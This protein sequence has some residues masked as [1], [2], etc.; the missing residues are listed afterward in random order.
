MNLKTL[1][2]KLKNLLR[3]EKVDK[4]IIDKIKVF[5]IKEKGLGDY[6]T[7]LI[8]LIKQKESGR[9]EEIVSKIKK[10][11][12]RYFEKIEILNDY[13]N[14]SLSDYVLM[15]KLRNSYKNFKRKGFKGFEN[16]VEKKFAKYKVN[17]DYV[18]ANPT[19]PLTLANVR[20]GVYGDV[21]ANILKILGYR[22][23]KEYY[24]N[25]R[26][27][28]IEL[29]GKTILAHLGKIPFGENFYKL[30]ILKNVAL[31]IKDKIK[32][33]DPQKIGKIAGDYILEKY[34]KPS[35][36]K[37]GTFHDNFFFESELY[38]GDLKNKV[39]KILKNKNLI[40]EREGVLFLLLS[41]LGEEKD[42]VLIRKNGE[43]TYFFSD[44]IYH[45]QKYFERK[46]KIVIL[47][48]GADHQNQ[49]RRLKKTFS[50]FKIKEFQ[51]KPILLQFVHIKKGEEYLKMSKRKGTVITL[52]D[53]LEELNPGILRIFFLQKSP[54]I[55]IE[56]DLDLAKKKSEE[57]PYWY[58]QY[59]YA[60]LN[61]ILQKAKEMNLKIP[62]NMDEQK[63]ALEILKIDSAK[64][65]FKEIYKF[66]DLLWIIEKD[67]NV[68]L[69][70]DYAISISKKIHIF[71]EKEKVLPDL[72]KLAFVMYLKGF[73]EFLFFVLGIKPLKKI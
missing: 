7:N 28:Q 12:K 69:I 53:I 43:P 56:L 41:K 22:V 36:K 26:G 64:D 50:I 72:R 58:I 60:R 57:N 63:F 62:K 20:G 48:V 42:E 66:N 25:D 4:E 18:S 71:Y 6:S 38:K 24:V 54:D 45:Y 13:L 19:G 32:T 17:I 35:L 30:E 31:D 52:D 10:E 40:E 55:T 59:A 21:L 34:I 46:F 44:I 11:F 68:N 47:I 51:F 14:F 61:S 67:L 37:F 8:F 33:E 16:D 5:L 2:R 1:E 29:L 3:K 9:L 15:R 70:Y 49:I 73:M 23:T 65:I 27:T 39:L